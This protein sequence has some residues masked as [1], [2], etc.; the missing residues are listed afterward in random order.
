MPDR[1]ITHSAL[2]QKHF[3]K[4]GESWKMKI[5]AEIDAKP[6]DVVRIYSPSTL[7]PIKLFG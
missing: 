6:D 7:M 4:D 3:E 2:A 1:L 5:L